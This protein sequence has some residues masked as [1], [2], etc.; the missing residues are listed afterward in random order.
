MKIFNFLLAIT[1]L[2][3]A[4]TKING[5]DPIPFI[6]MY[7]AMAVICIMAMFQV[8]YKWFIIVVVIP[9]LYYTT[10][11]HVSAR[12]WVHSGGVVNHEEARDFFQL[13]LAILV[14]VFQ[15]F[16]SFRKT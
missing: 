4:F 2:V 3:F 14:L 1:F 12:E 13:A 7:G 8:Y 6:L 16:R 9:I 5:T 10:S 15:G 11:V